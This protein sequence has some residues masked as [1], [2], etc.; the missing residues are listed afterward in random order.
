MRPGDL[1]K[2]AYMVLVT[3]TAPCL[4]EFQYKSVADVPIGSS[5]RTMKQAA[6][7]AMLL[8]LRLHTFKRR[9]ARNL[10]TTII[11]ETDK[12]ATVKATWIATAPLSSSHQRKYP[13]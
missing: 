11:E 9:G 3:S 10:F 8:I 13:S 5:V 7:R 12:R 1:Y 2:T 4:S 6:S